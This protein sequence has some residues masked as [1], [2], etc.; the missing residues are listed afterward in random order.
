MLA[1]DIISSRGKTIDRGTFGG[2]SAMADDILRAQ[3]F[4]LSPVTMAACQQVI[5]T[6]P[7]SLRDA[8]PISRMP[9]RRMWLEWVGLRPEDAALQG[10]DFEW[11][12]RF[13]VLLNATDD[14]LA[15][16]KASFV[17]S[18]DRKRASERFEYLP[19]EEPALNLC[20]VSIVVDW[21]PSVEAHPR[22]SRFSDADIKAEMRLSHSPMEK[23]LHEPAQVAAL[24]DLVS[25]VRLVESRYSTD[26]TDH[27]IKSSGVDIVRRMFRSEI[28]SLKGEIL[29]LHAAFCMM[30]SR[31]CVE[32]VPADLTKLNKARKAKRKEPLVTYSTVEI[33]LSKAD[34]RY[35]A[36]ENPTKAEIKQHLVRGHFKIRKSGVFFWRPYI[37]GDA[38]HGEVR[39]TRYDVTGLRAISVPPDPVTPD[40]YDDLPDFAR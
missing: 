32:Y 24:Q 29:L 15:R 9:F 11:P 23:H 35:A 12:A 17:W 37:R 26:L 2:L 38:K 18:F 31:N 8:L 14:T 25:R 22:L 39:R 36:K 34:K 16:F 6:R 27:L 28:A 1:D 7:S 20:P 30:N 19:D 5:A 10:P 4:V 21:S 40:P 33:A 3:R 13:G